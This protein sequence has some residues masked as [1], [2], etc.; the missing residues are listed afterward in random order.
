[1]STD[2]Q[3]RALGAELRKLR[4][5]L[6]MTPAGV[7]LATDGVAPMAYTQGLEDAAIRFPAPHILFALAGVYFYP[8][9]KLMTI[10][11]HIGPKPLPDHMRDAPLADVCDHGWP[12]G[13]FCDKC[14][15]EIR[16]ARQPDQTQSLGVSPQSHD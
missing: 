9:V 16:L 1:M 15:D 4:E 11:G 7:E 6:S 2:E 10:A 12:K 5:G 3:R 13:Y 14:A 8:Y